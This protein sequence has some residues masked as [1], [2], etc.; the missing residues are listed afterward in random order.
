MEK[1]GTI[2]VVEDDPAVAEL[3]KRTLEHGGYEVHRAENGRQ[4]LL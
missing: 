2:L 4:A 1:N 3:L